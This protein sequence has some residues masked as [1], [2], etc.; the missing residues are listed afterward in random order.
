MNYSYPIEETWTKQEIIEVTTF[1]ALV[2]QAYESYTNR[3]I[4]L[5]A[6]RSFKTIVPSKSEEKKYFRAF[7]KASTYSSYH[8]IKKARE[9]KNEKLAMK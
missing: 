1:F 6:Y 3:S 2:E 4:L 8:V 7:E 5:A 9:T